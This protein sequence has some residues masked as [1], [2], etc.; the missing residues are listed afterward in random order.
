MKYINGVFNYHL[1]ENEKILCLK[2]SEETGQPLE[3]SIPIIVKTYKNNLSIVL[4]QN[5]VVNQADII[6]I[7]REL[8]NEKI[9][10][11]IQVD[12]DDASVI[13]KRLF[14]VLDYVFLRNNK[15]LKKDYCPFAD[16]YDWIET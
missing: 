1:L 8:H 6:P 7:C 3:S 10:T 15:I 11:A 13:N 9:K 16:V 4:F 12:A 14:E 5:A 2:L